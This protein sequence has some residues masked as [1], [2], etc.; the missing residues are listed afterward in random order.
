[1]QSR[2]DIDEQFRLSDN[3]PW[4]ERVHDQRFGIIKHY[5]S[6]EGGKDYNDDKVNILGKQ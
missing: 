2:K 3:K 5:M 6:H 1:M 4:P